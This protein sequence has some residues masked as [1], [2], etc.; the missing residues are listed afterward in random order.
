MKPS[1][2]TGASAPR[3]PLRHRL[4]ART[5]IACSFAA[6]CHGAAAQILEPGR[7]VA[8]GAVPDESTKAAVLAR[9]RE[10]YG[11]DIVVDQIT[12]GGVVTPAN[13][14]TD[15]RK[16]L[17]PQLKAISRGQVAI[18]GTTVSLKGE[19][20]SEA[21][22][23][24]IATDFATALNANYTVRNSLRVAA[25]EQAALDRALANRTIEFESG[26]AVL[27]P[28]GRTI[29]D[30]M[31]EALKKLQGRKV[32]IIG[33]TDSDGARS[34]NVALSIARAEAVR[35]YLR[36]RGIDPVNLSAS[37]AGPDRPI[38]TNAT[39]AGRARNRRI[40]FRIGA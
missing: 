14:S 29:L 40:E 28:A 6:I 11:A 23:Q 13:W 5:A 34:A 31:A 17:G 3:L 36:D 7:V 38:A 30:E 9:L 21:V 32:E 33:H 27:T 35:L 10:L 25:S 20:S 24:Q 15:V 2:P 22:R 39:S 18:D 37:G 4:L 19:V 12:V 8:T 16:A 26:S 1:H